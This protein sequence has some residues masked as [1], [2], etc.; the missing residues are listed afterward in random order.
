MK[1]TNC[2]VETV[3]ELKESPAPAP[4]TR[5]RKST[6]LKTTDRQATDTVATEAAPTTTSKG[7]G[8]AQATEHA[9]IDESQ[10][11]ESQHTESTD[12]K[13]PDHHPLDEIARKFLFRT[14][15]MAQA[16][17]IAC[18]AAVSEL[19]K[20]RSEHKKQIDPFI[21]ESN[22][23][24]FRIKFPEDI[25]ESVE[26][27]D[28][29]RKY[30]R[31]VES[32]VISVIQRSLFIGI[33][34]EF[35][36]FIGEFLKTIFIKK[37]DLLNSISRG[38]TLSE[39][40]RFGSVDAAKDH[41]LEK[42]VES[43]RRESYGEQF[44]IM[45]NRFK[46]NTLKKFD[47]WP[48]FIEMTQRR[49]LMTHNDGAVSDQYLTVCRDHGVKFNDPPPKIGKKLRIMPRYFFT[50]CTVLSV[51]AFML[52]HTL[53]RKILP[54]EIAQ[55]T[56]ALT[57][58]IYDLLQH[59]RWGLAARLGEFSLT[60]EMRKSAKEIDVRIRV[61][62][63]AIAYKECKSTEKLE[64]LLGSYDWSATP[65]DFKLAQAVLRDDFEGA[66]AA[67]RAIGKVGDM[68][69]Q[70]VYH[71]WPLFNSF[72]ERKDFRDAY[73]EIYGC[74]FEPTRSDE[75]LAATIQQLLD[76]TVGGQEDPAEEQPVIQV[77][78]SAQNQ[79]G[80]KLH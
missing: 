79:A 38:I 77:E 10:G 7:S 62:N 5:G 17:V 19:E 76:T 67:M 73:K 27:V 60:N 2:A 55:A 68:V 47:E 61:I 20:R 56:D 24:T 32:K 58:S 8:G 35:D 23:K 43:I 72:R 15:D 22:E 37:P 6:T 74:D 36:A 21:V 57:N 52:T 63:L 12:A 75:P 16:Y 49:N 53:W 41:I 11:G 46:I 51:V 9:A 64:E 4:R 50:T 65:R 54:E 70:A 44:S 59:E 42:E 30:D 14:E 31:L 18:D 26:L 66:L 78:R 69:T 39:L 3:E 45:E 13:E 28:A 34:S 29:L 71:D 1:E 80:T 33:F 25:R 40:I 48:M